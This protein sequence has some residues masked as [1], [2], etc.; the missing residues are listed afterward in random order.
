MDVPRQSYKESRLPDVREY[1]PVAVCDCVVDLV[2][3]RFISPWF[4]E[5]QI[6][7]SAQNLTSGRSQVLH[8]QELD[9]VQPS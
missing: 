7:I 6:L 2:D 4:R 8:M 3:A 9:F 1:F 5:P